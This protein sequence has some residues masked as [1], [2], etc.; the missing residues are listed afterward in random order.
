MMHLR[1]TDCYLGKKQI[2]VIYDL[3]PESNAVKIPKH[4]VILYLCDIDK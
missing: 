2:T 3:V 4:S 1:Q